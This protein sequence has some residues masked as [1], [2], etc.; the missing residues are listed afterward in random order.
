MLYSIYDWQV[1]F[2]LLKLV[3][4]LLKLFIHFGPWPISFCYFVNNRIIFTFIALDF[5]K[6]LFSLF[7][8]G[9]GSVFHFILKFLKAFIVLHSVLNLIIDVVNH[10]ANQVLFMNVA[11]LALGQIVDLFFYVRIILLSQFVRPLFNSFTQSFFFFQNLLA[12][13]I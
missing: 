3:K 13:S 9:F 12:F 10:F 11:W 5:V 6:V 1:I 4:L 2:I 8:D 7:Y